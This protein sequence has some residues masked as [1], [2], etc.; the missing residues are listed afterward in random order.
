MQ[1]VAQNVGVTTMALYRYFS[2]K[3]DLV[4]LMIDSVSESAPHFGKPTLKW[5]SRLKNW[6]HRCL[7]IYRS[8]PWFLEATSA[9]Q[10]IMGPNEL[11]WMEAALGMLAEAGLSPEGRTS[12]FFAVIAHVRGHATFQQIEIS[13]GAIKNWS[14][15]LARLLA[16][17]ATHYPNLLK[18]LSSSDFSTGSPR[19]FDFGLDC[20]LEG[21]NARAK[22]RLSRRK[23]ERF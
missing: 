4:D 5:S 9:R 16:P 11:L 1:R 13:N 18:A 12:A 6:A 8:H 19:A 22:P 7:A 17:E 20:I 3:A 14:L 10:S 23:I 2:G 21:I 15:D